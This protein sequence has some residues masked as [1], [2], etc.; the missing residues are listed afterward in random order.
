[1]KGPANGVRLPV[2]N[3]INENYNFEPQQR[4]LL[5]NDN[6]TS[7]AFEPDLD[8][9]TEIKRY[10]TFLSDHLWWDWINDKAFLV[11]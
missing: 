6:E 3:F 4:H 2:I 8:F 10:M 1:V 7:Y 11:L 5:P 9:S